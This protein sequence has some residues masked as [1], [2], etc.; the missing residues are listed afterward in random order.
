[1]MYVHELPDGVAV[2]PCAMFRL[3]QV[4]RGTL[5]V[6]PDHVPGP[7]ASTLTA[8]STAAAIMP[9]GY[10]ASAARRSRLVTGHSRSALYT[11]HSSGSDGI[12]TVTAGTV[13]AVVV[14]VGAGSSGSTTV[15]AVVVGTGSGGGFVRF[16]QRL[17]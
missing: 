6:A 7:N 16:C 10:T 2:Q 3:V 15:A 5:R 9:S 11:H 14:V 17:G 13:V 4:Q 1:M 12:G 8:T